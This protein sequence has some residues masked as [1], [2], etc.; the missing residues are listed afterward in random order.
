MLLS[1]KKNPATNFEMS[2]LCYELFHRKIQNF[3]V[4]LKRRGEKTIIEKDWGDIFVGKKLIF[5]KKYLRPPIFNNT[6]LKDFGQIHNL[7]FRWFPTASPKTEKIE[8][9]KQNEQAIATLIL[10]SSDQVIFKSHLKEKNPVKL[11]WQVLCEIIFY[12]NKYVSVW[13]RLYLSSPCKYINDFKHRRL[14]CNL[15]FFSWSSSGPFSCNFLKYIWIILGCL[16]IFFLDWKYN[17]SK[18]IIVKE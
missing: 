2:I 14:F 3:L 11:K 8:I 9:L 16:F 13:D 12:P 4:V 17:E 1:K 10:A 7:Q 5:L 15:L 18:S 6:L